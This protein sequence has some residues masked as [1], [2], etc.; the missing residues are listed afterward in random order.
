MQNGKRLSKKKTSYKHA[1]T[2]P[3][4]NEAMIFSLPQGRTE[5]YAAPVYATVAIRIVNSPASGVSRQIVSGF[6]EFFF[7][8]SEHLSYVELKS[9]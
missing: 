8:S 5:V 6:T 1:E 4:F 9:N 3:I 7:G 2:S